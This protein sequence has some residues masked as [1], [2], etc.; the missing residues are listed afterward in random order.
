MRESGTHMGSLFFLKSCPA[1]LWKAI[2]R[3]GPLALDQSEPKQISKTYLVCQ[4]EL[5]E[6]NYDE[7]VY[8]QV[9]HFTCLVLH[10]LV[11]ETCI[12]LID[13]CV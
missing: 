11:Y 1:P 2:T 4:I 7:G 9:F 6:K 3:C 8:V 13:L 10:R 5:I 12:H